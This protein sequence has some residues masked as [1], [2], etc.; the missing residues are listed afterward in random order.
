[1]T[2]EELMQ[3]IILPLTD[4]GKEKKQERIKQVVELVKEIKEEEQ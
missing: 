2:E 4:K 1:M 3:L